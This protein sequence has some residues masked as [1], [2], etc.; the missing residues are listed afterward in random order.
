M[1]LH[2]ITQRMLETYEDG[3]VSTETDGMSVTHFNRLLIELAKT[4]GIAGELPD[5]L[6]DCKPSEISA[7]TLEIVKHVAAAKA[8]PDPN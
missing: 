6:G 2:E 1:K 5:D 8:P 4:S 3:L 7:W